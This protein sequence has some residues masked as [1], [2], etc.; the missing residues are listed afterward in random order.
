[1]SKELEL[2]S[3]TSKHA[4][5]HMIR[6]HDDVQFFGVNGKQLTQ[7]M[8]GIRLEW[9]PEIAGGII[10]VTCDSSPGESKWLFG[11]GIQYVSWK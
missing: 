8:N 5:P 6:M 9:C 4:Q 10:V 3:G 11:G 1:M 2:K 7:G